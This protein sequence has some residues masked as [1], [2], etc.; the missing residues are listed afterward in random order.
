MECRYC[1]AVCEEEHLCDE[2]RSDL[3]LCQ[4]LDY[5]GRWGYLDDETRARLVAKGMI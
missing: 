3:E 5:Y 4:E 1:E 2:C